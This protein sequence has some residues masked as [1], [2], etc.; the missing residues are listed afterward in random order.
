MPALHL[1]LSC[2]RVMPNDLLPA[3]ALIPAGDFLMGSDEG[4]ETTSDRR[5]RVHVDDFSIGVQPVTNAEYGRFV[6]DTGHRSPAIYELPLVV[7][8]GRRGARA[9][10]PRTPATP[11]S[12]A[13]AHPPD[14]SRRSSRH[15]RPMGRRRRVLRVAVEVH[16]TD[17]PAAD[18]SRVGKGRARRR[19]SRKRYPWGDRLDRN[20]ANFLVDPA[21]K[22]DARHDAVPPLSAER[23]RAVRYGGQRVGVGPRLVRAR[24][25]R[26]VPRDGTRRTPQWTLCGSCAAAAGWSLSRR[27]CRAAIDM[28]CRQTHTRMGLAFGLHRGAE[29]RGQRLKAKAQGSGLR[30][31]A[32]A[33]SILK[34]LT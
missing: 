26:H 1:G 34:V 18:R 33:A 9:R 17:R 32:R 12:G 24:L 11:T 27:C 15:A 2:Q 6:Q 5:T 20:M 28:R 31:Q 13:G 3:F 10:V 19:S 25:L 8:G 4:A 29:A 23:L 7:T 22:A 14:R 30:A 21:L 16:R